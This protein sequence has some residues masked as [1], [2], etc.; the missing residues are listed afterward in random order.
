MDIDT[1]QEDS[2]YV[3]K[4]LEFNARL[5]AVQNHAEGEVKKAFEDC[6][7]EIPKLFYS[8]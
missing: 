2:K 8:T 6:Y 5:P 7:K 1:A 3:F 4:E